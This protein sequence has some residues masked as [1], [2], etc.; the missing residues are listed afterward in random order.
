MKL[1][2]YES[3]WKHGDLHGKTVQFSLRTNSGA[4][5]GR[6]TFRIQI[7]GNLISVCICQKIQAGMEDIHNLW[8]PYLADQI[9][10]HPDSAVA[11]FRLIE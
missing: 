4:Y 10:R 9:E 5:H 11:D 7:H 6:G 3:K 8:N 2:Y 1:A